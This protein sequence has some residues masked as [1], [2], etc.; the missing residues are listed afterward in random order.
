MALPQS[1]VTPDPLTDDDIFLGISRLPAFVI[2]DLFHAIDN[3]QPLEPVSRQLAPHSGERLDLHLAI[4]TCFANAKNHAAR[5][6]RE[7]ALAN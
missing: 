4:W 6:E 1:A 7:R 2:G 3:D 5:R